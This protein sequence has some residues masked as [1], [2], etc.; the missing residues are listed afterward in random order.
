MDAGGVLRNVLRRGFRLKRIQTFGERRALD[1][2]NRFIC[3]LKPLRGSPSI[4]T[5][6]AA[7]R[8]IPSP[9]CKNHQPCPFIL[10][11]EVS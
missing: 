4:I 8:H 2:G 10:F 3:S 9:P 7:D 5:S 1:P 6:G 11:P